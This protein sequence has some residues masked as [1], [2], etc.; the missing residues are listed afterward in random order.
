MK[1]KNT[2]GV[3]IVEDNLHMRE[4]L[5]DYILG[6]NDFLL[7][8][9]YASCEEM[10]TAVKAHKPRI[11]LMD[12]ELGGMNGI[13][14]V[15]EL[16]RISPKSDVIM[17]TVFENSDSVFSAL[18]A[19]ASGYLTKTIDGDELITAIRECIAGGAPMTMNIAKMVISSFNRNPK[20]PLSERE[21]EVLSAL[22]NGKSYRGVSEMIFISVDAVKYHIKSIYSKLQ[23]H[24]KQEAIDTARRE[25]YI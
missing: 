16:K 13:E 25:K 2:I 17:V 1:G 11:V 14:G 10:L 7:L 19:G 5:M 3:M 21:T 18:K 23:A 20:S 22:A 9:A 24:S 4:A 15:G 8:G 6:A 12:I